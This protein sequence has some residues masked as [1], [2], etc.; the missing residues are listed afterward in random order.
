MAEDSVIRD[1]LRASVL[2]GGL[3][4]ESLDQL[5]AIARPVGIEAESTVF[6]QG[7][8][9]TAFFLLAEGRVKVFK[10][11]RDGR[12]ATIRHVEPGETFGESVLFHDTYP[13]STET[14]DDCRLYRFD[15]SEFR[16]LLLEQPR[17][18]LSV[19]GA[20]A[21][22]MM[23]LNRRVEELLLPVPARLAR[24]LLELAE[25]QLD[26][27][28]TGSASDVPRVVKLPTS[29]RELAARIGTVPET[30]SRAFDRQKRANVIRMSGG[31]ELIEILDF[32]ALRR[33]AQQ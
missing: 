17:L 29:K 18:S 1:D 25:E 15:T 13:S 26:A 5:A 4:D 23:L 32:A 10:L 7:D 28:V 20:M 6:A 3:D 8:P 16:A 22:L 24:Y 12:T 30:L 9:A 33:L 21:R 14:M 11:F 2:F 31:G 27:P 19:L